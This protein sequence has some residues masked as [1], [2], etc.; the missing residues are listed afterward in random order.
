M[1]PGLD[2]EEC[3]VDLKVLITLVDAHMHIM[4]KLP[5]YGSTPCILYSILHHIIQISAPFNQKSVPI[6]IRHNPTTNKV[7][8]E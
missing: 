1:L 8:D 4:I 3:D 7:V 6:K 5:Q 2:V